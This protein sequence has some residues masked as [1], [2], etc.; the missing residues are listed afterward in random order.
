VF[1]TDEWQVLVDLRG[2]PDQLAG[3]V[4]QILAELEIHGCRARSDVCS[5][6]GVDEDE[7]YE[8]ARPSDPPEPPAAILPAFVVR[9]DVCAH[10]HDVLRSALEANPGGEEQS[11]AAR[12]EF[13]ADCATAFARRK[14]EIGPVA[15]ADLTACVMQAESLD[16]IA[17]CGAPH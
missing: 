10:M 8:V 5:D 11:P 2:E 4:E 1:S 17:R 14:A 12:L 6:D 16:A 3:H 13:M 15:A 9:L 7:A